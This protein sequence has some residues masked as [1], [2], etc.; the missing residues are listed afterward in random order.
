MEYRAV[1][2]QEIKE[3]LAALPPEPPNSP[4]TPTRELQPA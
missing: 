2:T 1:V 3:Q 4:S